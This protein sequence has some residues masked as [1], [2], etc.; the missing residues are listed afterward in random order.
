[1]QRQGQKTPEEEGRLLMLSPG[2]HH[3]PWSIPHR[4][5][6]VRETL[7]MWETGEMQP[8]VLWVHTCPKTGAVWGR[9]AGVVLPHGPGDQD[10]QPWVSLGS[11]RAGGE[12]QTELGGSPGSSSQPALGASSLVQWILALEAS[13]LVQ[14]ILPHLNV[15]RWGKGGRKPSS[16]PR[17][18]WHEQRSPAPPMCAR[19]LSLAFQTQPPPVVCEYEKHN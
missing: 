15:H 2:G 4:A 7:P 19:P 6:A 10:S 5:L 12:L 14:W 18:F 1:M 3:R 8:G 13:S 16:K 9:G 17:A 11:Q